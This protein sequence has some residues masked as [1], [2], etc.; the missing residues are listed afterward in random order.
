MRTDISAFKELCI[1]N[2]M[3]YHSTEIY[4]ETNEICGWALWLDVGHVEFDLD[5]KLTNVVTY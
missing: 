5:G 3:N 1:K 2:N 4:D